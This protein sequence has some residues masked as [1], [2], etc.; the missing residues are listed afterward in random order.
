MTDG[1][2]TDGEPQPAA[3]ALKALSTDDGELLLFNCHISESQA[4]PVVFPTSEGL[5]PDELARSLF[6]MSSELP[7][8]LRGIAEAKGVLAPMGARHGL[9][10]RRR[11]DAAAHPDGHRGRPAGASAR[12]VCTDVAPSLLIDRVPFSKTPGGTGSASVLP[13]IDR[14]RAIFQN[15][16]CSDLWAMSSPLEDDEAARPGDHQLRSRFVNKLSA[17]RRFGDF[18]RGLWPA[19]AE[20]PGSPSAADY[21]PA[22]GDAPPPGDESAPEPLADSQPEPAPAAESPPESASE[23]AVIDARPARFELRGT[24]GAEGRQRR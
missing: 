12:V 24:L 11:A 18:V 16:P 13:I 4:N 7:D 17:A 22:V 19:T 6:R 20:Q 10:R 1:E 3:D 14:S 21:E 8:K 15:P 2:P 5:L 9:Q 23:P